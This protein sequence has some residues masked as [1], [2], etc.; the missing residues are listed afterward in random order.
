MKRRCQVGL[1]L[2]GVVLLAMVL[3]SCGHDRQLVS[4][5]VTPTGANIGGTGITVQFTAVGTYI[6]PPQTRDITSQVIWKS[7]APQVIDFVTPGSP[8]LATSGAF[9]GTNIGISAVVYSNP[10][11]PPG[12]TAVIGRS[13]V[14]V[15][16]TGGCA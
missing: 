6:H 8:G 10:A 3:P 15:T 11:N 7:D 9:C 4:I 16:A 14:N 2:S 12:G 1:L 5:A 13:T